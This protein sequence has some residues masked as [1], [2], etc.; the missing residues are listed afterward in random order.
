MAENIEWIKEQSKN[1]KLVV[2]AH[3]THVAVGGFPFE[4]MGSYLRKQ[5]GLKLLVFGLDFGEGSFRARSQNALGHPLSVFSVVSP[6]PGSLEEVLT[7]SRPS[8][9]ILDLR[10]TPSRGPVA[11]WMNEDR[12]TH[13]VGAAYD[14]TRR[15]MYRAGDPS[16]VSVNVLKCF[17]VLLFVRRTTPSIDLSSN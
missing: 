12:G 7:S 10:R 9:F 15:G 13:E 1:G 6:A 16:T 5:F 8:D 17:D 4:T 3:N 11:D 2:W 14:D